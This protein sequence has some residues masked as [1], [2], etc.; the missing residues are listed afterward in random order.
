MKLYEI[1][2]DYKR[3]LQMIEDGEIPEEAIKDT[4]ESITSILEDKVDN[5]ACLIKNINAEVEA[6][7]AEEKALAER[8]KAKEN[9]VERLKDYLTETLINN[10]CTK[11]ETA[12]NKVTFRKSEPV[13]IA[14]ET[15]FISWARLYR[16]DL[17]TY[18]EPK[19]NKT[20]IKKAL[21]NGDEIV[22]ASI[23]E[24][25]NIQIK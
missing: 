11:V 3:L 15:A 23:E 17:L 19:V 7:K 1:A 10:G 22:G 8:R 12:R 4:L 6:I 2:A 5:I 9:H 21:Q 14:D 13:H 20:A 16:D 24:K 18:S 25:Q